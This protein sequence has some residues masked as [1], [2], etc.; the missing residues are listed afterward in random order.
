MS[1][2]SSRSLT[3]LREAPAMDTGL[4]ESLAMRSLLGGDMQSF[5]NG[6]VVARS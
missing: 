4:R 3:A 5:T 2:G 6:R 1:L